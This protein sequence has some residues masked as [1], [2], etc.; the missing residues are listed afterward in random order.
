MDV[1]EYF[2]Q[3][4][5]INEQL[6]MNADRTKN[7]SMVASAHTDNPEFVELMKKHNKL[8]QENI[9]LHRQLLESH[10]ELNI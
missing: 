6:S 3:T 10:P 1:E 7:M 4:K 9:E 5:H 2:T 8:I